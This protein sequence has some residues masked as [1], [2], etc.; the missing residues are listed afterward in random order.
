MANGRPAGVHEPARTLQT[1][2]R[3]AEESPGL[4]LE[5]GIPEREDSCEHFPWP[6]GRRVARVPAGGDRLRA[7]RGHAHGRVHLRR[8]RGDRGQRLDPHAGRPRRGPASAPQ[9]AHGGP[10]RRQPHAGGQPRRRRAGRA[11][12]SRVQ[13]RRAPVLFTSAVRDRP[14][15]TDGSRGSRHGVRG[16]TPVDGAPASERV[17][18]VRHPAHRVGHGALLPADALLRD[19]RVVRG[20]DRRVRPGHGEQGVDGHGAPDGGPV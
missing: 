9:H 5:A 16:G 14:A 18:G 8:R 12:V 20:G 17:R 15:D 11:R 3:R 1:A 13:H 6:P 7:V 19:P 10:A 2:H 4:F